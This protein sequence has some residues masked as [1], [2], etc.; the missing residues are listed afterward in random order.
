MHFFGVVNLNFFSVCGGVNLLFNLT[1]FLWVFF[2]LEMNRCIPYRYKSNGTQE[3]EIEVLVISAQKGH[4]MQFPK[5]L[6]FSSSTKFWFNFKFQLFLI[7]VSHMCFV[8]F[9]LREVGNLM[10]LWSRLL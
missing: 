2:F 1:W 6:L 7:F 4:G 5:V 10:S 3:N 8:L 9:G